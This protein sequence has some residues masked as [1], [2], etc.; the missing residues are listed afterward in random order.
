MEAAPKRCTQSLFVAAAISVG[1]S[2]APA[3]SPGRDVAA[4]EAGGTSSAGLPEGVWFQPNGSIVAV[5]GEGR[6]SPELSAPIVPCV[7]ALNRDGFYPP[8]R[9]AREHMADE[10]SLTFAYF[11]QACAERYPMARPEAGETLTFEQ[12]RNNYAS[13]ARCSFET[14][15]G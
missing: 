15:Y 12:A 9:E 6:Q 10:A 14:H 3:Q 4:R 7:L 13:V 11:M 5:D 1:C 2:A 8:E